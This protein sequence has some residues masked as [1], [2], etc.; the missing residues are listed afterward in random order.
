MPGPVFVSGENVDLRVTER[1]DVEFLQYGRSDPE[2]RDQLVCTVPRTRDEMEEFYESRVVSDDDGARLIVCEKGS[3]D[4]IGEANLFRVEHDHGE[5]ALWLVPEVHGEGYGT[6]AL[7]LLVDFAFEEKGLHR[8]YGRVAGLNDV[9]HGLVDRL[10]F[11][12][13]GRLRD[14]LYLDGEYRDAVFYGLLREEWEGW[15]VCAGNEE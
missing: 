1:E 10:G 5:V 3:D 7:S 6:E 13:E 8:V 12:E 11:T 14:H 15:D 9:S 4:P 2:L